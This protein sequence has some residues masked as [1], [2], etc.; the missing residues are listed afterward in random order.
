MDE[1]ILEA[2]RIADLGKYDEATGTL[3]RALAA[4]K[5]LDR[6]SLV[7]ELATALRTQGRCKD[8]FDNLEQEIN[9]APQ[10]SM[11]QQP[12]FLQLQMDVLRLR[13]LVVAS[14]KGVGAQAADV[15]RRLTEL[16]DAGVVEEFD[17]PFIKTS[18]SYYKL[19][20]LTSQYHDPRAWNHPET[21]IAWMQLAFRRLLDT[22]RQQEALQVASDCMALAR[23]PPVAQRQLLDAAVHVKMLEEIISSP[24]S[25]PLLRAKA[26]KLQIET[27]DE[28]VSQD[29]LDQLRE[30]AAR[31]FDSEGHVH[32]AIDLRIQQAGKAIKKDYMYLTDELV[33]ELTGYFEIYET[34]N[35]LSPFQIAIEAILTNIAPWQAFDLRLSLANMKDELGKMA[36]LTLDSY[37]TQLR[38]L[39][40]WLTHSGKAGRVI[41]GAT[42]LDALLGEEDCRLLKG[43][44]RNILAQ[45]YAQL[46]DFDSS[47]TWAL[48]GVT[49]FGEFF[50]AGRA[51]TSHLIIQARLKTFKATRSIALEESIIAFT[52][53]EIASDLRNGM[54]GPAIQKMELLVTQIFTPRNEV[55]RR[56]EWLDRM[57]QSARS[58]CN[59]IPEEGDIR[60]AAVCQ[61][62]ALALMSDGRTGRMSTDH[63]ERC[64]AYFDEAVTLYMKHHRLV[65]AAS[66]RQMQA[67]AVFSA[68]EQVPAAATLERCI[69][70][71][72]LANEAFRAVENTSLITASARWRSFYIY[73]AWLRGWRLGSEALDALQEAE[74]AWADLRADMTVFASLGAVSRRQQSTSAKDLRDT[75]KRAFHV[76]QR[77]G[78]VVELWDWVQRAKARSLSDQLGVGMLIPA[79]LREEIVREPRLRDIIAQEEQ[80][81]QRIAMSEAA[82]RLR[83]RGELHALHGRMAEEP[84]LKTVLDL[85]NGTPVTRDQILRLGRE[86]TSSG[87]PHV[88]LV[89]VDWVEIEDDIWTV[90]LRKDGLPHSSNCGLTATEVTAWKEQWLDAEDGRDPPLEDVYYDEDEEEYPLRGLDK[91]VA[92]LRGLTTE[93][94]LV[95]FCP[96]GILHS[97]PL[98]ALCI[99]EHSKPVISQNAVVYCASLTSFWQC[100]QRAQTAA[101]APTNQNLPWTMVGVYEPAPGRRFHQTEQEAV[102]HSVAELASKH[103]ARAVAVAVGAAATREFFAGALRDSALCHFHGHCVL[104]RLVLAD[105]SLELGDGVLSARDVFGMSLRWSP[106]ITLVACDS[107]SQGIAA[108]DEPLGLVTALLC[109][110]AASVAGT[111]WPTASR[112]GREFAAAFYAEL[113][114][115]RKLGGAGSGSA[116]GGGGGTF[117]MAFAVRRAVLKVRAE[118]TTRRPYQWA[119]FVLHGSWCVGVGKD[120]EEST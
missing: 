3:R 41:E 99:S 81:T 6:L 39:A 78:R 51:D 71:I 5:G 79:T 11:E 63:H 38:L 102:H 27:A 96:T 104:D 59:T 46:E 31:L 1:T 93:G 107:A 9:S 61:D 86:R 70:L 89:F 109:A 68:F 20:C 44:V 66:T 24:G 28:S 10:S 72:S 101:A 56:D 67:L 21:A 42:A 117:N 48:R 62:R 84:L 100:C 108:G 92:P 106:H 49:T 97:I 118:R 7:V 29:R 76:C 74:E 25:T 54:V 90:V 103:G 105:Q 60:T 18:L 8:S 94:D 88:D 55:V 77:E 35:A 114:V 2:R 34:N 16:R 87:V 13:P 120:A 40:T 58:L 43:M 37:M 64:E 91:L 53:S 95:V 36:G 65:E 19:L 110:G 33:G 73:H 12:V 83:L 80:L 69:E 47:E 52:E 111:I 32:G 113:E 98:H 57:E 23:A 17:A 75:Y 82:L 4:T 30:T 14:F 119:A 112:T 45:A 26:M 50:P 85:R 22:N 15:F 115:Q 116:A